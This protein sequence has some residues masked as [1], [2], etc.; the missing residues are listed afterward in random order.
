MKFR[1]VRIF[2][3]LILALSFAIDV[4]AQQP[5]LPKPE[6]YKEY[7]SK[8]FKFSALVPNSWSS[9]TERFQNT[10][11]H[12]EVIVSWNLPSK[13]K[14]LNSVSVYADSTGEVNNLHELVNHRFADVS[15][16]SASKA[17][18]LEDGSYVY[19]TQ[20]GYFKIKEYMIFK[21]K[22]GYVITLTSRDKTY[23]EGIAVFE[24]FV[25]SLKI[26]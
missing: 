14:D 25:K 16:L 15:I 24:N 13:F 6:L 23:K 4:F 26:E 9:E 12:K 10:D 20:H 1:F 21:N 19:Y 17:V 8:L 5:N 7:K 11:N 22:K 2:S 18:K 3:V